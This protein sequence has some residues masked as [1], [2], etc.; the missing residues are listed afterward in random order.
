MQLRKT[1]MPDP[2]PISRR[3]LGPT[4]V[5]VTP[6]GLGVMQ[7]SG[8][9]GPFGLM[10]PDLSQ[11]DMNAIVQ[12]ALDGGINWFDTAEMYGLGRSEQ[13]LAGAL[14]AAGQG[15]ADVVVATKWLPLL[16]TAGNI[17]RTVDKRLHHLSGYPIDLYMIHQPWSFSSVEAEMDAMAGLAHAG[18][19]RAVGVSNFT[20]QA[21]WRAHAALAKHGLPLAANQMQY[22]L[23]HR[24][25]EADGVLDM[26][27]QLGVTI[28]AY[29][30]L[31]AGILGGRYH[32]NPELLDAAPA[33]RR[34]RLRRLVERSRPLVEALE[35]IAPRYDATPAQVA[36]NWVINFQ[37]DTVV[38]IP[39][40]TRVS[41]AADSAG[42]MRFQLSAAELAQLDE[43]SRVFR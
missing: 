27:R 30:P 39:G 19:I 1:T 14:H 42:A 10:F 17:P 37:G 3:R 29:T 25:I 33:G 5:E 18:K 6:I 36:L 20:A 35:A 2:L 34:L 43:L 9:R 40:A 8:G 16:R 22:S 7:F 32:R 15:P 13:A 4:D 41:Q 24:K 21:M 11:D 38:A 26:A 28:I 23:L 31:G 12:A